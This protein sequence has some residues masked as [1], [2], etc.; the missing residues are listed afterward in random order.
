M[1]KMASYDYMAPKTKL[2]RPKDDYSKKKLILLFDYNSRIYSI[3]HGVAFPTSQSILEGEQHTLLFY[4]KEKRVLV[5]H[6]FIS[7]GYEKKNIE[8]YI[9]NPQ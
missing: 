1:R 7:F 6:F 4:Y 8:Q 3:W 2:A 9:N 5:I